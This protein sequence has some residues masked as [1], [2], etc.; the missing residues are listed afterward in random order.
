M[1]CFSREVLRRLEAIIPVAC[2]VAQWAIGCSSGVYVAT[3][4]GERLLL[5]E[6]FEPKLIG[7]GCEKERLARWKSLIH[8]LPGDYASAGIPAIN[9]CQCRWWVNEEHGSFCL[10][11]R[12]R[13]RGFCCTSG[14]AR[15]C[16]PWLCEIAM[17]EDVSE[18]ML[19]L[20]PTR[21]M[22]SCNTLASSKVD[23]REIE[24][25]DQFRGDGR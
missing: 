19:F 20:V 8:T 10:S 17:V 4:A 6:P 14:Q 23:R 3:I 2:R 5:H 9:A 21:M 16:N 12:M 22:F 15:S 25:M 7:Q 13:R 11:S 18:A 24:N 1:L